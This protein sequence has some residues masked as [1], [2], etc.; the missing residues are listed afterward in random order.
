MTSFS[1]KEHV[2]I[3][4]QRLTFAAVVLI[5][6]TG[7]PALSITNVPPSLYEPSSVNEWVLV[8][9]LLIFPFLGL[10]PLIGWWYNFSDRQ[11]MRLSGTEAN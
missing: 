10:A 1:A 4:I 5:L 7:G 9:T 3:S 8:T 11:R 2:L 6:L